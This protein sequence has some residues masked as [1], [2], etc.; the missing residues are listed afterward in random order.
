M[1]QGGSCD[2]TAL[3]TTSP[4]PPAAFRTGSA[5]APVLLLVGT[6]AAPFP[7]GWWKFAVTCYAVAKVCCPRDAAN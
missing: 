1:L 3:D 2:P 7:T 4:L 6:A 5:T